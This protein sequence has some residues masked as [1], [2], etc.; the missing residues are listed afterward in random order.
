MS[1]LCVAALNLRMPV[2]AE[3]WR[4]IYFATECP[5]Q[6]SLDS[7]HFCRHS[8]SA[9]VI[10]DESGSRISEPSLPFAHTTDVLSSS[11]FMI[12]FQ[13]F[14]IGNEWAGCDPGIATLYPIRF[15]QYPCGILPRTSRT[16]LHS[17]AVF[18][19][20]CCVSPTHSIHSAGDCLNVA[21]LPGL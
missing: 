3:A 7:Q 14:M 8:T 15:V 11:V 10:T 12:G 9:P 17:R 20:A 18:L 5:M 2:S 16:V 19:G 21:A 4:L 6:R 1:G 13:L